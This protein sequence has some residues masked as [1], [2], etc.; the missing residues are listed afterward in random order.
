MVWQTALALDLTAVPVLDPRLLLPPGGARSWQAWAAARPSRPE[1]VDALGRLVDAAATGARASS[2]S[3]YLGADLPGSGS[4]VFRYAFAAEPPAVTRS[5]PLRPR[6]G[7]LA[8][9]GLAAL[10]LAGNAA[11]LWRRS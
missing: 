6:P 9:T 1:R 8:L 4:T 3:P 10:L 7:P 5:V 11:L 2:Y